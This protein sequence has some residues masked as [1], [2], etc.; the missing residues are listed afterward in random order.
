VT[1]DGTATSYKVSTETSRKYAEYDRVAT[2]PIAYKTEGKV[3]FVEHPSD[4]AAYTHPVPAGKKLLYVASNGDVV[5]W[6]DGESARLD[7]AAPVD[8]RPVNL[9]DRRYALYGGRIDRYRHGALGDIT[10]G[11]R[12][13]IVN[14]DR[15]QIET[16]IELDAPK[17][18]EGLSPIV[19]DLNDDGEPELVT[20]VADS[21]DG[22]R[23]RV[24]TVDGTELATGPIYG[25]GWRH[26]LAVARFA[27]DGRPELAVVRKPHVDRTVEFYC[28]AGSELTVTA[29]L[30]GYATHTYG[31]RNLDQALAADLDGDSRTEL[32]VPTTDRQRLEA[33]RRTDSG[34]ETSWSLSLDGT[35]ST[36]IAGA[37]LNDGLAVGAGT[38]DGVRVWQG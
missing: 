28:L 15:E 12:L 14:V 21:A 17:V 32:L 11:S 34:A 3:N 33:V 27:P 26:Q 2:T 38:E 37:T 16:D 36:N 24:Y 4:C 9:G 30:P 29:Q 18:F 22:A 1:D 7:A 8:A 25:P 23:I 13:I 31:S 19:A 20:T 35:L 5:V 10:E 6:Q